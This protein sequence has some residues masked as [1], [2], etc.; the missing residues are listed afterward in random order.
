M[1]AAAMLALRLPLARG[2][3]WRFLDACAILLGAYLWPIV[4]LTDARR[5]RAQR[6]TRGHFSVLRKGTYLALLMEAALT[7]SFG[8][9]PQFWWP[10]AQGRTAPVVRHPRLHGEDQ[11]LTYDLTM[12]VTS[13]VI[14][15][16][17]LDVMHDLTTCA[18]MR[19]EARDSPLAEHTL[20][21]I[22]LSMDAAECPLELC[23][24]PADGPP[25]FAASAKPRIQGRQLACRCA[26]R[27]GCR[28]QRSGPAPQ[29]W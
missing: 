21:P 24:R 27:A 5:V 3:W 16:R 28:A 25:G 8:R 18:M 19:H 6:A 13:N 29:T 7:T 10:H 26:A 15:L 14:D 2:C 11:H 22:P 9:R 12:K 20:A 17:P 4:W 1:H 23:S